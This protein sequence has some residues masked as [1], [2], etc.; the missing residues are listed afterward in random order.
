VLV[1]VAVSVEVSAV[2]LV[3]ETESGSRLHPGL[4][5]FES[6]L[7]TLQV[8]ETVPVNEFDGVTV[9]VEVS[10]LV[11]PGATEMLVGLAERAKLVPLLLPLGACQKFPQP[12]SKQTGIAAAGNHHPHLPILIATPSLAACQA[13]QSFPSPLTG[14]RLPAHPVLPPG[15]SRT[16][17]QHCCRRSPVTIRLSQALRIVPLRPWLIDS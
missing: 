16:P 13:A 17:A 6:E 10:L 14:Y 7:V 15:S 12:A 8:S 1:V 11:A 2:V 3:I 4:V 5:G 9:M